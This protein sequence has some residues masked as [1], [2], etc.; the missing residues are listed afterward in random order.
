MTFSHDESRNS[1]HWRIWILYDT[2]RLPETQSNPMELYT[3]QW[4]S[5]TSTTL[6]PSFSI[7]MSDGHEY[8]SEQLV[9]TLII[10]KLR[11]KPS[12]PD[13]QGKSVMLLDLLQ[14]TGMHYIPRFL[15]VDSTTASS[16]QS[17]FNSM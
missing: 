4:G 13:I 1:F 11:S 14:I 17:F 2:S 15:N 12:E 3:C 5:T 9:G 10:K 7:S 6:G 16:A 8:S